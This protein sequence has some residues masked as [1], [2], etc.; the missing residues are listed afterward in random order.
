VG[1]RLV[2]KG[3]SEEAWRALHIEALNEKT[4]ISVIIEDAL[5]I[6]LAL[7][8]NEAGLTLKPNVK[9]NL[10]TIKPSITECQPN[11]LKPQSTEVIQ[12]QAQNPMQEN[13]PSF[14]KDNPWL[15]ILARRNG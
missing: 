12:V 15:A 2:L 8:H 11:A 13:A 9:L 14:V 1:R 6:Y 7:K 10:R 5:A 4:P 3:L